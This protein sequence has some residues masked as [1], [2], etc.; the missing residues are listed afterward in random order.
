V[1]LINNGKFIPQKLVRYQQ[2]V[3]FM[4]LSTL[5]KIIVLSVLSQ[6]SISQAFSQ[7]HCENE[8][9]N[10][11]SDTHFVAQYELFVTHPVL[12]LAVNIEREEKFLADQKEFRLKQK[13]NFIT[14]CLTKSE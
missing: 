8:L 1:Y 2:G 4:K 12:R 9:N 11:L 7:K 10:L 3:K 5:T 13:S 14:N 6:A